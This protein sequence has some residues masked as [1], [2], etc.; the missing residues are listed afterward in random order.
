MITTRLGAPPSAS[1]WRRDTRQLRRSAT[2][3]QWW[4]RLESRQRALQRLAVLLALFVA[5]FASS[6]RAERVKDLASVQGV[7]PN[8]GKGEER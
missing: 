1:A 6:A 8:G 2:S 4:G 3:D 7:R 5:M